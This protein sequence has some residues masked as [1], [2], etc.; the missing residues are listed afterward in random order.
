MLPSEATSFPVLAIWGELM[1][2]GQKDALVMFPVRCINSTISEQAARGGGAT[3]V[4]GG[5]QMWRCGTA[6]RG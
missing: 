6:G 2:K 3:P 4:P 1:S 5:A